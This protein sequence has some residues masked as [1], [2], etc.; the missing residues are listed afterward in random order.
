[1][2]PIFIRKGQV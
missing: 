2:S 1:M